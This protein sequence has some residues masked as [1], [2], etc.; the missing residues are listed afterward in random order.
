MASGPITAVIPKT[1]PIFAILLPITFPNEISLNPD[2]AAFKL[3][4]NSG[5]EVA[6]ETTVSPMTILDKCNL[7]ESATEDLTKNSPPMTNK[8]SPKK[9]KSML[10]IFIPCE[11][12]N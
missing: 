3:T 8:V 1:N 12:N 6:K 5:A 10:I 4:N 9:M 11:D 2:N 7:K